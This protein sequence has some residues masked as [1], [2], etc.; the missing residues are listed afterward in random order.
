[1]V[2]RVQTPVGSHV[3]QTQAAARQAAE[4]LLNF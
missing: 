3:T 1:M 4:T 2:T